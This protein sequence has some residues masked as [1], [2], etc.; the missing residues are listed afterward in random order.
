L[1]ADA[2]GL[3]ALRLKLSLLGHLGRRE[4]ASEC[5]RRLHQPYPEP[6]VAAVMRDLYRGMPSEFTARLA[7]GL[8]MAGLPEG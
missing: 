7:K 2:A 1:S 4:E 3:P 5:L 8:R 6:T